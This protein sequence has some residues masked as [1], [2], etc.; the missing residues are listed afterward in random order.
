MQKTFGVFSVAVAMM[1]SACGPTGGDGDGDGGGGGGGAATAQDYARGVLDGVT[2]RFCAA[3]YDCAEPTFETLDS[4]AGRFPDKAACEESYAELLGGEAFFSE[5]G[6]VDA[7][8]LG[9][10]A[11]AAATCLAALNAP[12]EDVCTFLFTDV[13]DPACDEVFVGLVALGGN[14]ADSQEC[15]GDARCS[16]LDDECYGTCVSNLTCG[17]GECVE[18]EYCGVNPDTGESVCLPKLKAGD[19]CDFEDNCTLESDDVECLTDEFG[20]NGVCTAYGSLSAGDYCDYD[21]SYCG[22]GLECDLDTVECAATGGGGTVAARGETC[23]LQT[24]PCALG[25]ACVD[26]DFS[27]GG[28]GVCGDLKADGENCS[29]AFECAVGLTCKGAVVFEQPPVTGTCAPFAANGE[30]CTSDGDCASRE[31]DSGTCVVEDVC[32]VP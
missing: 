16:F 18:G 23:N 6:A 25:S 26:I 1:F 30:S 17:E 29:F 28:E 20:E 11:D 32:V 27:A 14:C 7:G 4:G 9:Y 8:R 24:T 12:P 31:C 22:A 13:P 19:A 10:D 5:Q 15:A 2:D 3:A 21:D